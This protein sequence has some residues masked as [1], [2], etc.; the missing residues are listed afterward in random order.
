VDQDD[1]GDHNLSWWTR[2]GFYILL[3]L[4]A[5]PRVVIKTNISHTNHDEEKGN[6]TKN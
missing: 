5:Y 1:Q 3:M 2:T 4:A 6:K